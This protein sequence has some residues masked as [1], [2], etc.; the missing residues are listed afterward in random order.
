MTLTQE[1]IIKSIQAKSDQLNAVD[2]VAC[3]I[4]V[5]IESVSSGQSD[6]PWI[7]KLKGDYQPYKPCK[8]TGMI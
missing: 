3:P 7:L 5:T 4:D 6:Q 8:T 2:L 1:Q